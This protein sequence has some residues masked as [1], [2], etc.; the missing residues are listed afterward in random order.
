MSLKVQVVPVTQYQQ[1]C[2]IIQCQ[3][4]GLAAIVDPGGDIERIEAAITKMEATVEKILLTHGHMD[5]CAAADVLRQKLTVPMEGPEQGDSFWIDKL[6]EWCEMAGF[7]R[8][9]PFTPDRWLEDGDTVEVTDLS[10]AARPGLGDPL[11]EAL[12]ERNG[13]EVRA[14]LGWTDVAFTLPEACLRP[15]VGEA[16]ARLLGSL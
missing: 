14:K 9:E 2:S 11:I 1:N 5:H 3:A 10:P 4:T 15:H 12:V 6:P 16:W 13:L 7:P 8:A